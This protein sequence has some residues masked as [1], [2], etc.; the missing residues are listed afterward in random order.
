MAAARL[1]DAIKPGKRL[2]RLIVRCD[3]VTLL[4][5]APAL[6]PC[7]KVR[8]PARVRV[9]DSEPTTTVASRRNIYMPFQWSLKISSLRLPSTE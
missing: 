9:L 7:Y 3:V 4:L 1:I 6:N 5:L 8:V 2:E